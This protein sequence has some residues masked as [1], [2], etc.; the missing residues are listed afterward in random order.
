MYGTFP[1]RTGQHSLF[2]N[3]DP[4]STDPPN[5]M[6]QLK[7]PIYEGYLQDF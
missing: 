7:L 5:G 4:I 3:T 6:L 1:V 2:A